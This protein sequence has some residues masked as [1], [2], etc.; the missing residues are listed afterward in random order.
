MRYIGNGSWDDAEAEC[1]KWKSHLWSINSYDEWWN[2][3]NS[4]GTT[5]S[6]VDSADAIHNDYVHVYTT[7]ILYIGLRL[8]RNGKR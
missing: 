3:Y 6:Y 2:I 7:V 1:T 4:F 8:N 5:A